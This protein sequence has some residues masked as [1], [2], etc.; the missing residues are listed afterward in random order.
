MHNDKRKQFWNDRAALGI[1]A[2]TNDIVAKQIEIDNICKYL[3]DG[4]N[5][6]DFGCGN[7]ITAIE[8]A[9]RFNVT[10]TGLDYAEGMILEAQKLSQTAQLQGSVTFHVGDHLG[11]GK[12]QDKFDA[13]Y[14]ERS[15]INLSSWDEQQHTIS[16]LIGMLKPGGRYIMCECSANGLAE[17]NKFRKLLSLPPID[18]PWHNRY[19]VDEEVEAAKIPGA[20]LACVDECSATYY[21][22]SRVLNAALAA[23]EGREPSYE[24]PINLLALRLPPVSACAQF[25]LWVWERE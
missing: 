21:F 25:K 18:S 5:V 13:I 10:L 12:I 23:Q 15:L 8:I 24:D 9:R 2:G 4:M 14:T 3:N 22:A 7:G 19:L 6:F 17:I 16:N 11:L 1:K 20:R